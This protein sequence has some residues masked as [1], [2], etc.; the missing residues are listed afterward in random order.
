MIRKIEEYPANPKNGTQ[1]RNDKGTFEFRYGRWVKI[2]DEV[3]DRKTC[4]KCGAAIT[5]SKLLDAM[6][7]P[8]CT[9]KKLSAKSVNGALF[10]G[11][12]K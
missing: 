8:N 4:D 6:I 5:F 3:A 1:W 12:E 9:P 2:T 7:C 11:E 10:M